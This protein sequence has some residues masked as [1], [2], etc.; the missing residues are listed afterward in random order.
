MHVAHSVPPKSQ[1]AAPAKKRARTDAVATAERKDL[2]DRFFIAASHGEHARVREFLNADRSLV[3][4]F[5]NS[6]IGGRRGRLLNIAAESGDRRMAEIALQYGA[7]IEH[8]VYYDN[9]SRRGHWTPFQTAYRYGFVD[10]VELLL[11]KG[12]V[13]DHERFP[14]TETDS[15]LARYRIQY[16]VASARIRKE[17]EELA[18][19]LAKLDALRAIPVEILDIIVTFAV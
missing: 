18:R 17:R 14:R 11:D 13:F 6:T 1:M 16:A 4:E 10:V 3:H 2:V 7:N 8:S 19:H 15:T 5:H 12:A 9:T